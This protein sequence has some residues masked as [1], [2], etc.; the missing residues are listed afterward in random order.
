MDNRLNSGRTHAACRLEIAEVDI[1]LIRDAVEQVE[2]Q[3]ALLK[4]K[5]DVVDNEG[6]RWQLSLFFLRAGSKP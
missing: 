1:G 3:R 6:T 2:R 4:S 5:F